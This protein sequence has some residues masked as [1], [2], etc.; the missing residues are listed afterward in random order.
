MI[1][2]GPLSQRILVDFAL[3]DR[4]QIGVEQPVQAVVIAGVMSLSAKAA[5]TW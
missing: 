2:S 1:A 5:S 4:E 3:L